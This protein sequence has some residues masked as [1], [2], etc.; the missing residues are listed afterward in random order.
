[1]SLTAEAGCAGSI[2]LCGPAWRAAQTSN[3]YELLL[4]ENPPETALAARSRSGG[5]VVR[6]TRKIDISYVPEVSPAQRQANQ[7]ALR[8]R[9][10]VVEARLLTRGEGRTA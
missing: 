4:T 8:R 5:Q 7:E 9:Q 6:Q 1:M 2:A 3:A 10:A